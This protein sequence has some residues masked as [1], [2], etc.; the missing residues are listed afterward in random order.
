M[1]SFEWNKIFAA[2]ISGALLIMV[3]STVSETL[4]HDSAPEK[5]AYTI[6]VAEDDGDGGEQ[7]EDKGPSLAELLQDASADAGE[8]QFAKCQSCHTIEKGGPNRTG[9]NLHNI[10]GA[11]V[12][13][14]SGFGYS[15]A[16][17]GI[18]GQWTYQKLSDWLAN[19]REFAP[20]NKMSFAGLRR[21]GQRAD[22]I[23]YLRANSDNPPPLPEVQQAAEEAPAEA[24]AEAGDAAEDGVED[25]ASGR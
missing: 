14:A 9:P 8:R 23:A 6:E 2:I 13:A 15:D 20:G 22:L 10:L 11:D 21:D 3:I 25:G 5:P 24:D 12:A 19:P 18:G 4:M 17:S 7:V 16:L 1:D